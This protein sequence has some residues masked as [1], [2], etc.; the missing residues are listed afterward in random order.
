MNRKIE[1][2]LK[3]ES[4]VLLR[5]SL[6]NKSIKSVNVNGLYSSAKAFAIS[7]TVESGVHLVVLQGKD[8]AAACVNDLYQCLFFPDF[9]CQDRQGDDEGY[10]G[11]GTAYCCNKCPRRLQGRNVQW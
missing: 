7:D 2:L 1:G 11:Q 6:Q 8:E 9:R 4:V 3:S 5:K 10:V